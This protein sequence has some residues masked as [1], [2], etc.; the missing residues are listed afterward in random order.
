[1][2]SSVYAVLFASAS[3]ATATWRFTNFLL[4]CI[5][6]SALLLFKLFAVLL[7]ALKSAV[8]LVVTFSKPSVRG[9][10]PERSTLVYGSIRE[11][12]CHTLQDRSNEALFLQ[13]YQ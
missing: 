8:N 7:L 1:L 9:T 6:T 11:F 10:V 5:V 2:F 12:L 13:P 3:E 4:Y